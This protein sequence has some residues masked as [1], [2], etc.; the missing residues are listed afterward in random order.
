MPNG[1]ST[2][3]GYRVFNKQMLQA[4]NADILAHSLAK[5]HNS[6]CQNLLFPV[7]VKPVKVNLK[8][9]WQIFIFCTL[10]G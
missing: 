5:A 10:L 3:V 2:S 1:F 8:L 4:A 9:N 6:E 7:Q